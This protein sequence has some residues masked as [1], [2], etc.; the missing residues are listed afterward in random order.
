MKEQ[1]DKSATPYTNTN[2]NCSV[3]FPLQLNC[4]AERFIN[5]NTKVVEGIWV[6]G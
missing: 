6:D 4:F 5:M 2:N 1:K 3:F